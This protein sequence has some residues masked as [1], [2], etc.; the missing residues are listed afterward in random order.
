M[1]GLGQDG[2]PRDDQRLMGR[3]SNPGPDGLT[4]QEVLRGGKETSASTKRVAGSTAF[5]MTRMLPDADAGRITDERI[6][7]WPIWR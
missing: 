7:G 6:T 2:G 4:E 1:P 3:D 5:E